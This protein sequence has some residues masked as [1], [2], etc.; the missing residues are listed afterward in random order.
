MQNRSPRWERQLW[1]TAPCKKP[2]PSTNPRRKQT[3]TRTL[4]Q[5]HNLAIGKQPLLLV[6]MRASNPSTKKRHMEGLSSVYHSVNQSQPLTNFFEGFKT[7]QKQP[8]GASLAL[9][10]ETNPYFVFPQC[11]PEIPLSLLGWRGCQPRKHVSLS[12]VHPI[13]GLY[14]YN[15]L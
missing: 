3:H 2:L 1:T 8:M 13:R 6:L 11:R 7:R 9:L 15:W 12:G 5:F 4:P 10:R 14:V